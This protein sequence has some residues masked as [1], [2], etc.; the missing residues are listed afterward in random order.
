MTITE[1]EIIEYTYKST[2]D[3]S[4]PSETLQT[5][6]NEQLM[7]QAPATAGQGT[8]PFLSKHKISR[9][10][11]SSP[12]PS[13]SNKL[14]RCGEVPSPRKS[15]TLSS[16][17]G[18]NQL[19]GSAPL[20][21]TQTSYA[22]SRDSALVDFFRGSAEVTPIPRFEDYTRGYFE[23]WDDQ[24][25]LND[26][27]QGCI[28]ETEAGWSRSGVKACSWAGAWSDLTYGGRISIRR[29]VSGW[30]TI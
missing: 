21:S 16:S 13:L 11:S 12:T 30:L 14:K 20:S 7:A 6:M 10:I 29:Q 3:L 9:F 8:I 23:G 27:L 2:I 25:G 26:R 24:G 19:N 17:L 15:N 28:S 4:P 1:S 18:V 22:L 5:P